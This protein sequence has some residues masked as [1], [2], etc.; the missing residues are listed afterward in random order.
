VKPA[1]LSTRMSNSRRLFWGMVFIFLLA[2]GLLSLAVFLFTPGSAS[3]NQTLPVSL[4]SPLAADYSPDER[5]VL[6]PR[7]DIALA[8]EAER[9][10]RSV[11]STP[12]DLTVTATL[13]NPVSTLVEILKTPVPTVTPQRFTAFPT[14]TTS[15]TLETEDTATPFETATPGPSPTNGTSVTPT[16]TPNISITLE[17][18]R[19]LAGSTQVSPVPPT[20][21]PPPPTPTPV[22]YTHTPIPVIP[23][24]TLVPPSPIPPTPIPPTPI[25]PTPIP[26]TPIPP[27]PIPPT[28]YSP[29]PELT[30][31]P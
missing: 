26:P 2:G 10:R 28:P 7:M 19:T 12:G 3:A 6:L 31:Y 5:G 23:T 13:P 21:T 9:D 14:Q 15:P 17:P 27:T 18:T 25:P 24:N 30:P 4:H 16:S 8:G 29:P 22:L 11:E 1:R 20:R